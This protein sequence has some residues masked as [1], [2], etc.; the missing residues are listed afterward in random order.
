MHAPSLALHWPSLGLS[1]HL[2]LSFAAWSALS[3][4]RA[5]DPPLGKHPL[6]PGNQPV[7]VPT[8]KQ[9][10]APAMLGGLTWTWWW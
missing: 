9:R 7:S 8:I 10:K 1:W 6:T 3:F 2:P 5:R 4:F